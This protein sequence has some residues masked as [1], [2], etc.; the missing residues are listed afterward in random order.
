M[1]ADDPY[2]RPNC[3]AQNPFATLKRFKVTARD[4]N[5]SYALSPE[6]LEPLSGHPIDRICRTIYPISG[7]YAD[8]ILTFFLCLCSTG[9][10]FWTRRVAVSFQVAA[11]WPGLGG[12]RA[13]IRRRVAT[14]SRIRRITSNSLA[15][16]RVPCLVLPK[17]HDVS[18]RLPR[19]FFWLLWSVIRPPIADRRASRCAIGLSELVQSAFLSH[20][21]FL[22]HLFIGNFIHDRHATI[23]PPMATR[24]H[25]APQFLPSQLSR[26]RVADWCSCH[27][28][29][30]ATMIPSWADSAI[31]LHSCLCDAGD[32]LNPDSSGTSVNFLSPV[33][34]PANFSSFFCDCG[35]TGNDGSVSFCF[36]RFFFSPPHCLV[37]VDPIKQRRRCRTNERQ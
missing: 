31:R 32:L 3:K 30:N 34:S 18:Q 28:R 11:N 9:A 7:Y 16:H 19:P 13:R 6:R 4:M 8:V 15:I 23:S 10:R 25:P 5:Q 14:R 33:P 37:I 36:S 1:S 22:S 35:I 29:A 24:P 17:Y 12:R 2:Y 21:L 20:H 26:R 27:T